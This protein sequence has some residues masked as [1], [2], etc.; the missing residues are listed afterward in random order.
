MR[1]HLLPHIQHRVQLS[2]G[3]P[4]DLNGHAVGGTVCRGV[5]ATTVL[6][7]PSS[8]VP[9]DS[10]FNPSPATIGSASAVIASP[11]SDTPCPTVTSRRSRGSF[12]LIWVAD[13]VRRIEEFYVLRHV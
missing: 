10:A 8:P 11:T 13:V 4:C 5:G 9:S 6:A 7:A 1:V 12:F 2:G 3:E